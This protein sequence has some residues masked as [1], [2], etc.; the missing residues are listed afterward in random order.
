VSEL[1]AALAAGDL[2]VSDLEAALAAGACQVAELEATLEA[3]AL[4]ESDLEAALAA[5]TLQVCKQ[6]T[7]SF[8]ASVLNSHSN[9]PDVMQYQVT[10]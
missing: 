9:H 7:L 8:R 1:E 3:G 10:F 4:H 2:Q 6:P 5:G